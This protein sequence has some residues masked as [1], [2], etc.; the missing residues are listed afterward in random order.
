MF[1]CQRLGV[2]P[3][4]GAYLRDKMSDPASMLSTSA[5][6]AKWGAYM[7][8]TTVTHFCNLFVYCEFIE[9]CLNIPEKFDTALCHNVMIRCIIVI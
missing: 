6:F 5:K 1:L 2:A 8:D 7:Q 3:E 4:E 9:S